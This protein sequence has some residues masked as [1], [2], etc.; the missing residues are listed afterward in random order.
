[1]HTNLNLT[2]PRKNQ[3]ST[4]ST[5]IPQ[6]IKL[7][8]IHS[9]SITNK[10]K[11]KSFRNN[12]KE[13]KN[14]VSINNNKKKTMRQWRAIDRDQWI[15]RSQDAT[16]GS[17]DGL[18]INDSDTAKPRIHSNHFITI[19]GLLPHIWR[20]WWLYSRDAYLWGG[21]RV[22]TRGFTGSKFHFDC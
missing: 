1:M 11:K 22:R 5:Q 6:E 15:C 13:S 4:K 19:V 9:T 21:G 7:N 8:Q 12:K 14:N 16:V 10:W 17:C 18:N 2:L 3:N 20:V